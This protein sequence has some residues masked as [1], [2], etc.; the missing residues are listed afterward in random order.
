MNAITRCRRRIGGRNPRQ[1]CLF[2]TWNFRLGLR[3][4]FGGVDG[5]ANGTSSERCD[6]C[7][8]RLE[9]T[10]VLFEG[11]NPRSRRSQLLLE[12][13]VRGPILF[14]FPGSS[15]LEVASAATIA[16]R[17]TSASVRGTARRS[18][19]LGVRELSKVRIGGKETR[20]RRP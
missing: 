4:G 9:F 11:C 17:S 10:V 5:S 16:V 18:P 6:F 8:P 2:R 14:R 13:C 20:S 19:R 12:Q 7:K 3:S 15:L 1:P